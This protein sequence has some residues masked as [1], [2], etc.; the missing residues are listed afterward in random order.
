MKKNNAAK[1]LTSFIDNIHP[2]RGWWCMMPTQG[3]EDNQ[4]YFQIA[5]PPHY[6]DIWL[7]LERYD[8]MFDRNWLFEKTQRPD[9]SFEE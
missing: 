7:A 2:D 6:H 3:K 8:N 1:A 5:F 9:T 4:I